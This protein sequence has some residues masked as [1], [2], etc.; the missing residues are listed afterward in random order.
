MAIQSL[1]IDLRDEPSNVV[2]A[3]TGTNGSKDIRIVVD[4]TKIT[5]V[6]QLVTVLKRAIDR[7]VGIGKIAP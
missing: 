4:D 7:I 5:S 6:D 1:D 3:T 2:F